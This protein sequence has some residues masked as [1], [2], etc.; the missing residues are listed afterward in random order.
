MKKSPQK[1]AVIGECMLEISLGD[2]PTIT[3]VPSSMS[4]GGD[5]LN[6]AVYLS[7]LGVQV[8][9]LTALG[10]DVMSDWMIAQ[11]VGEGV[12]CDFVERTS[13]SPPGMYMIQVDEHGERTFLYWREN[14][15][16][17]QLLSSV[18]AAV[19]L[20]ERLQHYDFVYLSGITLSLCSPDVRQLLYRL[21][22]DFRRNGGQLIFDDNYRAKLWPDREK[23]LSDYESIYRL[24]DIALPTLDDEL[25]LFQD[26]D[27]SAVLARL[28]DFGVREIVLKKGVE[29]CLLMNDQS[30]ELIPAESVKAVDTTAAGDSFNAGYLAARLAGDSPS[31]AARAAHRLASTVVQHKGAIIPLKAMPEKSA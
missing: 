29:G 30:T 8:D 16:V 31:R 6:T 7:R 22:V 25:E 3:Q 14:S 21:I 12:G 11:W 20:F 17:R 28:K 9:Y 10:R 23:A 18:E 1:I 24:T 13:D 15:P 26:A 19:S 5:T 4:F 27:D 2:A